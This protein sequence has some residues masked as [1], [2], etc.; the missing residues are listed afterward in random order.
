MILYDEKND[1]IIDIYEFKIDHQLSSDVYS[2]MP[3]HSTE[4]EFIV[5]IKYE[6]WIYNMLNVISDSS[7]YKKDYV[8]DFYIFNSIKLDSPKAFFGSLIREKSYIDG[9]ICV[10]FICDYYEFDC[11]TKHLRKLCRNVNIDKILS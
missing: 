11:D 1:E 9:M 2:V 8:S 5:D 3:K 4:F 10:R 7:K 6:N